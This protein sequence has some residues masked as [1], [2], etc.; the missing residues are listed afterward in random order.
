MEYSEIML[1]SEIQPG[2]VVFARSGPWLVTSVDEDH[3]EFLCVLLDTGKTGVFHNV[4][5]VHSPVVRDGEVHNLETS[6]SLDNGM[7]S[8]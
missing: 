1:W 5:V 4:C 2:D 6:R 8:W 7:L 3:D